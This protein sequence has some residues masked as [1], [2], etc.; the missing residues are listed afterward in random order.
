MYICRTKKS[1]HLNR[2]LFNQIKLVLNKYCKYSIRLHKHTP[3]EIRLENMLITFLTISQVSAES[4]TTYIS[5]CICCKKRVSRHGTGRCETSKLFCICYMYT[6]TDYN[7]IQIWRN[8]K[9]VLQFI[10]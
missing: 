8:E 9:V 1:L 7:R 6:R 5:C 10:P 3:Q 2:N 4:S